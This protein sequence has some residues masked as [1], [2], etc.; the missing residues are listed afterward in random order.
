MDVLCLP[1]VRTNMSFLASSGRFAAVAVACDANPFET[2]FWFMNALRA[3]SVA[4]TR[5]VDIRKAIVLGGKA[6]ML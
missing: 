5:F 1:D 6:P 3:L 2:T 4:A